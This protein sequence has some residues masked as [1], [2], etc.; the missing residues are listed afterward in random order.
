MCGGMHQNRLKAKIDQGLRHQRAG[1]LDQAAKTYRQILS[2]DPR[3]PDALHLLGVI[4]QKMG[5][6]EDAVELIAESLRLK[7]TNV[8]AMNNLAGVLHAQRRLPEALEFYDAAIEASPREAYLRCN[9]S[10][11][12]KDLGRF[13]EAIEGYMSALELDPRSAPA[14]SNLG[15]VYNECGE[16]EAAAVCYRRALALNPRSYEAHSNF[17]VLLREQGQLEEATKHL[18]QSIVLNPQSDAAF[19]NLGAALKDLGQATEAI[20]CYCRALEL[21]PRSH[22]AMNNLGTLLKD[23]G[24]FA[25]GTGCFEKA[26]ALQPNFH[27]AHN[28]LGSALCELGRAREAAECF[29]RAIALKPAYHHAFSNLLFTLN[30]LGDTDRAALFAEHRRFDE[31]YGEPLR[32]RIQP[33]AN[34]PDPARR[35]RVGFVSGDLREHPVAA[36]IE[37]VFAR[38]TA[39]AFEFFCYSNFPKRDAVTERL[40][41]AVEHWRDVA[42]WSDEALADAIRQDGID[43]LVDLSG[44]TAHNRLLVF[45]RKPAPIQVSMIGYMQ[46][47][48]LSAMNYRVTDERLDPPGANDEFNTE[49]LIRLPA[50]AAPFQ[51]PA[52]CPPVNELPAL[53]NGFVTYASFNNLAKVSPEAVRAWAKILLAQP[54]ARLLLVGRAGNSLRADFAAQGIAADRVE[55][56]DRLPLQDFLA[57]HHRVDFLLDTFPYNGGTTT[58][59][60]LWM[61]VPLVTLVGEGTV[62]RTGASILQGVGLSRLVASNIEEY[63]NVAQ[64]ATADLPALADLRA[65]LR[66]KLRP[67]LEDPTIFTGQLESAFRDIWQKWCAN[68]DRLAK[69]ASACS[70]AHA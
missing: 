54:D 34:V 60:A 36:F 53:T 42:G 6:L 61:G 46:T 33:H 25:E 1:R 7:P 18:Q 47:T 14:L 70:S 51:P 66:G 44:H 31:F 29:R 10:N 40:R 20:A 65:S 2:D 49:K 48:G 17:G 63:V 11:V 59:L 43:I 37:P 58:L 38:H 5:N 52:D 64:A 50:G 27:L 45:A 30:Y 13:R 26:I 32:A 24:R 68:V 21:N 56:I 9:R 22:F 16:W 15:I 19:T 39:A 35:L 12:L 3:Q 28:N 69:P 41:S 55:V 67:L 23:A 62:A 4:A 57:L 8:S